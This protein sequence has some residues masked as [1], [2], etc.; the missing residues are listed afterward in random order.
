MKRF[1]PV[2]I[3]LLFQIQASGQEIQNIRVEKNVDKINIYYDLID[4]NPVA[5]YNI[6]ISCSINGEPRFVL[7]NV[8]GSTGS[9]VIPGTNKKVV[10]EA[11]S[12]L[13]ESDFI[14]IQNVEF[15]IGVEKSEVINFIEKPRDKNYFLGYNG[16]LV[17]FLGVKIGFVK[18]WGGYVSFRIM[19]SYSI[20]GGLIMKIPNSPVCVY[21][22][23]GIGNWA[24][25]YDPAPDTTDY[26]LS[27]SAPEVNA[28][29][30]LKFQK[31]YI[32]V[33]TSIIISSRGTFP[34]LTFGI[35]L[36]F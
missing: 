36:P 15:F 16:S 13:K 26:W 9:G 34:D 1:F 24:W 28:G 23:A 21:T 32:E 6:S 29:I 2:I 12:E 30:L 3:Y 4:A 18:K 20:S 35:G 33:G 7:R 8:Y 19:D 25:L 17:D 14:R 31:V 27:H 5:R 11:K 22:G 10:W